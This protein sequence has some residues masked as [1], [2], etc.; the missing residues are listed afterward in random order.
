MEV[1]QLNASILLPAG[2]PLMVETIGV[3]DDQMILAVANSENSAIC[4]C[5]HRPSQRANGHYH[6][7]PADLPCAGYLVQLKWRVRRFFCDNAECPRQTFAEQIPA[8]VARFARRTNRLAVEQQ[9]IAIE[10][11]GEVGSRLLSRL[12]MPASPDT[13]IRLVRRMPQQEVETPRVLG[14]DDWAKRKGHNYGTIL[15]DLDK[16]RVID[17]LEDRSAESLAEWLKAHPGVEVIS[18]DRAGEYAEGA[19]QGAPGAVQVA[20]RFHL[21][22]NVTDTVQRLLERQ[23]KKLREA[24]RQAAEALAQEKE[25]PV[26]PTL[27]M[28]GVNQ[29]GQAETVATAG[30][31]G[32][33]LD[34]AGNDAQPTTA[35]E[36][37]FAE[38]KALQQEG[39]SQRAIADHLSLSR[40]TIR[41]YWPLEEYPRRQSASQSLSRVAPYHTFVVKRWQEGCHNCQK[42]FEELE[43]LGYTS[44]YSSVWRYVNNLTQQG[45]IQEAVRERPVVIPSLSARK[46][47]WLLCLRPDDLKPE[48]TMLR[49]FLCQVCEEAAEAYRLAQDFGQMIRQRQVDKLDEWLQQA[50]ESVVAEFQ[51]FA[52][53]LRRDYQAVKAALTY[54]WS[55]GQV[56]GQV[57]RLKF[58]KRQ[59]YGR[60]NFDLLRRRVLGTSPP[61]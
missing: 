54:K 57:N 33:R 35:A 47:A 23:P 49:D 15:V 53:S 26:Q 29:P 58:I 14:V 12:K 19:T 55:N 21:M 7:K 30:V 13:L 31:A 60:A 2:S 3:G 20:D 27:A 37:R 22:Q 18:R 56:E 25:Q 43:A 46:G 44:S 24:A 52:A 40:G 1:S 10:V 59:G 8:V 6:R 34:G 4:P 11:G 38:V 51:R 50:E 45:T 41:R 5:C 39:W 9:Q 17:V 32:A 28:N 61:G 48:Q 16:H 36:L 42:L